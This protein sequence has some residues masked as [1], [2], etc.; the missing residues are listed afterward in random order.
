MRLTPAAPRSWAVAKVEDV[1]AAMRGETKATKE[2]T[3][4]LEDRLDALAS[5]VDSG[6]AYERSLDGLEDAQK[7]Y[8]EALK[9]TPGDAAT[10]EDRLKLEQ[11]NIA[12]AAA[13]E[14]LNKA[15]GDH[16]AG[17]TEVR[18]AELALEAARLRLKK[19]QQSS[20]SKGKGPAIPE[21]QRRALLSLKESYV[22]VAQA[23]ARQAEDQAV[24]AGKVFTATERYNAYRNKLIELKN[25]VAPGSELRAG[26]EEIINKL[27]EIPAEKTTVVK[28]DTS[29]AL[30]EL[31]ALRG[32]FAALTTAAALTVVPAIGAVGFGPLGALGAVAANAAAG[33]QTGGERF[34]TPWRRRHSGGPIGGTGEVPTLLEAGEYVIRKEAARSLGSVALENLNRMHTGGPV[35][36]VPAVSI[37]A[38][39]TGVDS[40]TI[41]AAIKA[42]VAEAMA[43]MDRRRRPINQT[44][45]ERVEPRQVARAVAREMA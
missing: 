41:T 17:S 2:A 10:T 8:A 16:G 4:A 15:M 45:N 19:A 43:A 23:A 20:G 12:V 18:S 7:A 5:Q 31:A 30:A 35:G 27:A 39:H 44:F 9:G 13:Q 42:G 37:R 25:T 22:D 29:L 26:L 14:R 11:A 34:K 32:G 40:A 1:A 6:F 21:E 28:V 24:A 36:G 3:E 38:H 33:G